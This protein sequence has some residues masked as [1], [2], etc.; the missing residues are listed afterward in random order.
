MSNET[1]SLFEK[2]YGVSADSFVIEEKEQAKKKITR[3]YETQFDCATD[4]II[5]CKKSLNDLMKDNFSRFDLNKRRELLQ[6]IEDFVLAQEDLKKD[7]TEM[8]NDKLNR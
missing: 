3:E 8:F 4:G 5:K 2:H 1:K 6:E 7:F